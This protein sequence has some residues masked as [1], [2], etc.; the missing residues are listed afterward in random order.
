VSLRLLY[1]LMIRVFAWLALLGRGPDNLS[2]ER[3]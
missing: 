2:V 1:L 3:R